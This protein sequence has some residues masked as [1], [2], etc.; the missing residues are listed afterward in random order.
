M[1]KIK[2]ILL[3]FLLVS[4]V[5]LALAQVGK[6]KGVVTETISNETV[7]FATVSLKGTT[8]SAS[9]DAMGSYEI[10][11]PSDGVL[12]FSFIGLKTVEVQINGSTTVDCSL[13][14][15]SEALDEA[16]VTGYGTY[17]KKEYTG[18]A[19]VLNTSKIKDMPTVSIANRLAGAATGIQITSGSG[20]PGS[21][22]AI[23]IRGM[24]SINAGNEPLVVIDGV[25]VVSG[26]VSKVGTAGTS[27]LSTISPS[28]IESMTVIKDAAAAS[29]YGSRAAN[30]VLI[31]TTKKGKQGKTQFNVKAD[32]GFSDMAVNYRP[33]LSG[34]ERAKV[35]Y[36]GIENY[37]SDNN[38]KI[39]DES[40]KN[41]FKYIE[42]PWNGWTDWRKELTRIGK[43]Q[44][45]EVSASGGNEKTR[46]FASLSY[47]N[48]EGIS[49]NSNYERITGRINVSHKAGIF[50]LDANTMITSINQMIDGE[51]GTTSPFAASSFY[52]SPADY[53]YNPDGS[54]NI[55]KGF[56][57]VYGS[58]NNPKLLSTYNYSENNPLRSFSN[59]TGTLNLLDG[60]AVKQL[61]SFDFMNAVGKSWLDPRTGP[62]ASTKGKYTRTSDN[63]KKIVSQTQAIY[64]R[65]F[66]NKH[67]IGV[68]FSFELEDYQLSSLT[69]IGEDYP[70]YSLPEIATAG[71]SSSTSTVSETSMISY[72]SRLNY[73][74]DQRYYMSVSYRR[75]GSSR[76]SPSERW[77]DFWSVSGSWRVASEKFWINSGLGKVVTDL[78]IRAS[79]GVNGTQ[80]SE[81]YGFNGL[82][83]YGNNY[84]NAPGS[85]ESN[86]LNPNLTWEKNKSFNLGLEFSIKNR[87]NFTIEYYN[88]DT[89]DLLMRQPISM[90]TGFGNYLKNVGSM[91]NRGVEIEFNT[92]LISA[93]DFY[94][95]LSVNASNNKNKI[96]Q[97]TNG[98]TE[99]IEY[100]FIR[101][102]G[103]P[104]NTYHAYER[105]G[106]DSNT[107]MQ[108][109]YK[110]TPI[111]DANGNITGYDRS[112]VSSV[113][114]A[115]KVPL[116]QMEPKWTGGIT[117]SFSW[118][119][120]SLS[121]TFTYSLGGHIYDH[122][123]VYQADGADYAYTG[124]LPSFYD[125][126]KIWKNPGDNAELPR[127]VYSRSYSASDRW[128]LST[129]HIRLK[130]LTLAYNLPKKWVN[131][132]KL[133]NLRVYT[134]AANL[135][136][137]KSKK[138]YVDPESVANGGYLTG[139]TPILKTV[140]FGI[141]IGF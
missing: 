58:M 51:G 68:L 54:F 17:T 109:Y 130:N 101:K 117:N 46:I 100:P 96:T 89:K 138:L 107:G 121:V 32:M 19:S 137:L 11:A 78:K 2:S 28:D 111:K 29:L 108:L 4:T 129:D 135:L 82:F 64:D 31:I 141:E 72:V 42:K 115:A 3:I 80:P 5:N 27:I 75:D 120:L 140:I 119:N 112:T 99:I 69:G 15:D 36:V 92:S 113:S 1:K 34:D 114:Q 26:N 13:D 30:G 88:R 55:S 128:M 63:Y 59:L 83:K 25:P 20:Q 7:P 124:S 123:G 10:D 33:L 47:T 62:G 14:S 84:N 53:P 66:A 18:S 116:D 93:K 110:N 52:V 60:L 23:R 70:N 134:S 126:N 86:I 132:I 122:Y 127:F 74:Y 35:L 37:A 39:D 16:I 106:I 98:Q 12:I 95:N 24:G 103:L 105:A 21:V 67:N 40:L 77:G 49:Y 81:W 97:L 38:K 8:V 71:R 136:T 50:T 131:Q 44:N 57:G 118:K 45:Y 94:W 79:Y 104:Y 48:Q 9:T 41:M 43:S 22:E 73:S 56:T 125:Y 91:N 102:V 65:T 133:E 61:V 76:L 87:F 139:E 6:V 85:A 90:V